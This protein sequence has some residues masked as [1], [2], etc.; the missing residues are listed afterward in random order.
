MTVGSRQKATDVGLWRK[1]RDHANVAR[2]FALHERVAEETRAHRG[3]GPPR[4]PCR[5]RRSPGPAGL[6]SAVA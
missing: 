2:V 6:S 5:S 1:E 3:N 4:P